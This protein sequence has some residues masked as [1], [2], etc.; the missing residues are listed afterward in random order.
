A[1][2]PPAAAPARLRAPRG[3]AQEA[4]PRAAGRHRPVADLGPLRAGLRRPRAARLPLPRALVGLPGPEHPGQDRARRARPA[5]GVLARRRGKAE[6]AAR[7]ARGPSDS[8]LFVVRGPSANARPAAN[9]RA[10]RRSRQTRTHAL[11]RAMT[12]RTTATAAT[13]A[14]ITRLTTNAVRRLL[15]PRAGDEAS[16]GPSRRQPI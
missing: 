14:R 7:H 5:R 1:R 4:L 12:S 13:M 6:P 15:R 2:R 8:E 11:R 3:L 9:E 16:A 10:A